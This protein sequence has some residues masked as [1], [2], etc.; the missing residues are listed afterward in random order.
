MKILKYIKIENL[1]VQI[2]NKQIIH[3]IQVNKYLALTDDMDLD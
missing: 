3:S 2:N 1:N